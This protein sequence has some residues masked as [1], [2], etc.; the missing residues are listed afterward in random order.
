MKRWSITFALLVALVSQAGSA[1]AQTSVSTRI[2]PSV[3]SAGM[4]GA[5]AAV[6]GSG[7]VNAWANPA[8][9]GFA[10][11]LRY[12]WGSTALVR[13]NP[14]DV[15]FQTNR[16]TY[17]WGGLGLAVEAVGMSIV[18]FHPR[19]S[20]RPLSVGVS[21][22]RALETVAS[23]RG[24]T[25]P[26]IARYADVAVGFSRKQ[27][28]FTVSP[29]YIMAATDAAANDFGLLLRAMPLPPNES[30][31]ST[32][33][34]TY[35]FSA[36]NY[37]DG[38]EGIIRQHRHAVAARLER[39]ASPGARA[40]LEGRFGRWIAAGMDPLVAV[41][42]AADFARSEDV[43]LFTIYDRWTDHAGLELSVLNTLSLRWGYVGVL[44]IDDRSFGVGFGVPLADF[45][46]VRY[47]YAR[48]PVFDNTPDGFVIASDALDRHALNRHAVAVWFDPVAFARRQR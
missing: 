28:R 20:L 23:L 7:D 2:D 19:E 29:P 21:L 36:L 16:F 5:S 24:R 6:V 22:A 48:F 1:T 30:G 26:V 9:L 3:R 17:G 45:A 18:P 39:P 25:T 11:G 33:D 31:R 4:G 35:G 43:G 32:L 44:G 42:V 27:I 15:S 34:L 12:H 13:N 46:S 10:N 40:G 14:D 8:L 41:T 47:D 38:S 37:D